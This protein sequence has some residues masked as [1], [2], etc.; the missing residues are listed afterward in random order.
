[1]I[2]TKNDLRIALTPLLAM[3]LMTGCSSKE[4]TVITPSGQNTESKSTPAATNNVIDNRKA[5]TAESF[6]A[7]DFET[8]GYLYENSIGDSL[9]F[10]IVKNNSKAIV[11][12][13]GNAV[14]KDSSGNSI[15][16]GS[17]SINVLGPDETS[18]GYFYFSDV[19]GIDSV[20]YQLNY[21]KET[22]YKPVIHNLDVS[23][24]L[25]EKNVTVTVTNVGDINAQFVEA[26]ALFFNSDNEVI[27]YESRYITD[28]DSEI[29]PGSTL[30]GQLSIYGSDY[31][32]AAVYFTGRS[33][34]S[35]SKA[36]SS[37][38]DKDFTV[39]EYS[40]ENSIG[41]TLYYLVVKNN[42]EYDAAI[43][44]NGTAYDANNTVI[45]AAD[46]SINVIGPGQTSICY[47]YFDGCTNIDHVDYQ[48][49]YET[50]LYYE[51][52]LHNLAVESTVNSNNVIVSVTNNG[53][54][55]AEFVEAYALFFDDSHNLVYV[56]SNYITDNDSEI[57]PG[58]TLTKQF[59][60][61]Q[62]FT[63]AEIYLTGRHSKH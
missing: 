47:F 51:D 45:G 56:D 8:E 43:N 26:Y 16:A 58:A 28:H 52:I 24:V 22:F 40:Y 21:S 23:Q 37:V 3:C 55:P 39:S 41:N 18:I 27:A 61:Y 31:D 4:E 44:A 34:G 32:H 60:P 20:E 48:M 59:D 19:S 25:N 9:Y 5:S 54:V 12:V 29:K 10:V 33:D 30:S 17:M 11:S 50:D 57:K 62:A 46:A 49:F 53:S 13:D 42:S 14:A 36:D 1:M 35:S 38:T 6:S 63:D 15:G 7:D 2:S